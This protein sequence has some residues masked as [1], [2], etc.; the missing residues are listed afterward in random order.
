MIT[1]LYK[2]LFALIMQSE[3]FL[4]ELWLGR[5]SHEKRR[6]SEYMWAEEF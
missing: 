3:D 1:E 4:V 5:F 6:H 2:N